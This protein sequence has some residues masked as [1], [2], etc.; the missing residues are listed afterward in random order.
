VEETSQFTNTTKEESI[1]EFLRYFEAY[2]G[3]YSAM[4]DWD[5]ENGV[6]YSAFL[7]CE[8][9]QSLSWISNGFANVFDI[10]KVILYCI[11]CLSLK[12]C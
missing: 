12:I 2:V 7:E 1:A 8:G 5:R 3:I 10:L 6:G 4:P 9:D 11:F